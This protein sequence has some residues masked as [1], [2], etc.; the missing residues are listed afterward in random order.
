MSKNDSHLRVEDT[1]IGLNDADGLIESLES[2]CRPF[3]IGDHGGQVKLE[4]LRL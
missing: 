1:G 3:F 2:V 4:I